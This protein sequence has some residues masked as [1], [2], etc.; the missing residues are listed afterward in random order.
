MWQEDRAAGTK[1]SYMGTK[2]WGVALVAAL[3][4]P[5]P[6][7][8]HDHEVPDAV[9]VTGQGSDVGSMYTATWAHRTG[10]HC[11][12]VATE[13]PYPW[14]APPVRWVPGTEMAV[15]FE[16]RYQ[17]TAVRAHA[18]LSGDPTT[19]TPIYGGV[20]IPHELRKVKVDGRTM[21][22]AVLSPPPWP[23]LWL[24]VSADWDDVDGC[25]LQSAGWKFR[26][27]LLPF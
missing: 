5:A 23:D 2:L 27:G 14:P 15:R 22:E 18:Y 17:P 20:D 12:V 8:A 10:R 11:S 1:G 9:L 24:D 4:F 6:A 16:T 3:V 21:W 25:G 7:V 13:G 26:A 19:G